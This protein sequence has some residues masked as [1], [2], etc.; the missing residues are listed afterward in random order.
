VFEGW[1]R[2]YDEIANNGEIA[3]GLQ[4]A[5]PKPLKD[6][7]KAIGVATDGLKDSRGKRLLKE[8]EIDLDTILLMAVGIY[9]EQ[10]AEK[11][12]EAFRLGRIQAQ[13][14]DRRGQLVQRFRKAYQEGG[15]V[16]RALRDVREFNQKNPRFFIGRELASSVKQASIRDAGVDTKMYWN[17]RQEYGL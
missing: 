10:I 14:S 6:L 1:L 11:T 4:H 5:S 2:A 15:D 13:I 16:D 8:D 12:R 17:V 9:P 3:K 7:I